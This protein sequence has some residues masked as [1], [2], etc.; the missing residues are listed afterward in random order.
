MGWYTASK[1]GT[2]S[3][4]RQQLA[5]PP[6][7][8]TLASPFNLYFAAFDPLKCKTSIYNIASSR[9]LKLVAR[10]IQLCAVVAAALSKLNQN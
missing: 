5:I 3:S 9:Q 7:P 6:K 2:A 8:Q 1:T 10:E 4:S